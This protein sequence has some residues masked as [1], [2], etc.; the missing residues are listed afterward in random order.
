MKQAVDHYTRDLLGNPRGR[1]RKPNAKTGSQRQRE[2]KARQAKEQLISV[3]SDEK[4]VCSFC[5]SYG[6][7][8]T[9]ICNVAQLGHKD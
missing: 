3:T 8:C 4:S 6:K 1:P 2:Y 5:V 9:G 7:R